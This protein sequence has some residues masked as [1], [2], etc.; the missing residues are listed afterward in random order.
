MVKNNETSK[1]VRKYVIQENIT[2]ENYKDCFLNG[3]QMLHSMRTIRS[4]HHQLGS[5]ELN[6]ITLSCFDDRR[7][8]L[9]DGI[10][11]YAY[12]HCQMKN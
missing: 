1:G 5:Y 3:K 10:H 2:H 8:I 12:G 11:S 6:K 9:D 7:Y 4:D